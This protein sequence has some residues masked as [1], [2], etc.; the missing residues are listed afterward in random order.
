MENGAAG[1]AI[2]V[3]MVICVCM[4]M[5]IW[6]WQKNTWYRTQDTNYKHFHAIFVKGKE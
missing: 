4:S 3:H 5:N 2:S 1:D 6:P